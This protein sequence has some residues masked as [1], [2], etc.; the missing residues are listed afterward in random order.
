MPVAAPVYYREYGPRPNEPDLTESWGPLTIRSLVRL[1]RATVSV[2][3][4][5]WL[6]ILAVSFGVFLWEEES[7]EPCKAKDNFTADVSRKTVGCPDNIDFQQIPFKPGRNLQDRQFL[8]RLLRY[9]LYDKAT[10]KTENPKKDE[11][12]VIYIPGD[13]GLAMAQQHL[14]TLVRDRTVDE[15]F[16]FIWY[17]L[18]TEEYLPV[19]GYHF[20]NQFSYMSRTIE[21]L[22]KKHPKK[23]FLLIGDSYGGTIAHSILSIESI[24]HLRELTNMIIFE[25]SQIVKPTL[26]IDRNIGFFYTHVN[27]LWKKSP[28]RRIGLVAFSGGLRSVDAHVDVTRVQR[29]VHVPSWSISG[30]P[31][32]GLWDQEMLVCSPFISHVADLFVEY[33]KQFH[34]A[35]GRE[36]ARKFYADYEWQKAEKLPMGWNNDWVPNGIAIQTGGRYAFTMNKQ[37][38]L[39]VK[40]EREEPIT[41]TIIGSCCK[42]LSAVCTDYYLCLQ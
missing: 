24:A 20:A 21:F 8:Y 13:H 23:R 14:A 38:W 26:L 9:N 22:V 33:G 35:T 19:N 32:A 16:R 37:Q 5:L 28:D 39:E 6:I 15:Q 4:F 18:D 29:A 7:C 10:L 25:S 30:V 2:L 17:V 42:P 41:I 27:K 3:I 11:I 36:I 34:N 31:D 12:I 40:L 1:T